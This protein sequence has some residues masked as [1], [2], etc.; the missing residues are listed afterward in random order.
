A[1]RFARPVL[2]IQSSHDADGTPHGYVQFG[3]GARLETTHILGWGSDGMGGETGR[4]FPGWA[5]IPAMQSLADGRRWHLF[6]AW[7]LVLCGAAFAPS[8]FKLWPS[9]ADLRALPATLRDHVLPWRV[10]PSRTLNPLQKLTYFGVI[11]V[12]APIIVL[13][14]LALSP[15][16]D[17][18]LHWL[19][20]MF[21][22][23]QFARIW[24]FGGMIALMLFFVV[25]V[26]MVALTGLVNNI[27]SMLSGWYELS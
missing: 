3:N 26:V 22:G 10:Q 9:R 17:S 27:R 13:S 25:H 7:V 15:T 8:A 6:F 16:V 19:P 5:T 18:W 14:G 1:S 20:A 23:R 2:A 11:F 4:A 24:H 21:G 12:L